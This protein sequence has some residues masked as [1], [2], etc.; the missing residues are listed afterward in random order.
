MARL[1]LGKK[2]RCGDETVGEL[3]DV[4]VDPKDK[5]LTHLVVKAHQGRAEA[6]LVAVDLADVDDDGDIALRCS[7]E[8]FRGFPNIETVTYARIGSDLVVDPKWDV[9]VTDV[10]AV[11]Y[12]DMTSISGYVGPIGQEAAQV[13]DVV[14]KGEVELR[15]SSSVVTSD[16]HDAGVIDGFVVGEDEQITHFVLQRGHLWRKRKVLVPL[17]AVTTVESDSVILALSADQVDDL[18]TDGS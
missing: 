13:Y 2:V 18:P 6:R 1:E 3:A 17:D 10:L 9:G 16:G 7:A 4:V 11:P 14:P 12:D 8:E 15:R 5:R